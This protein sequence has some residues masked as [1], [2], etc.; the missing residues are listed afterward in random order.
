MDHVRE[1]CA[2][3]LQNRHFQVGP[4]ALQVLDDEGMMAHA[5]QQAALSV[6]F[7]GGANHSALRA[8]E[9]AAEVCPGA[10]ILYCPFGAVRTADEELWLNEFERSLQATR[11][12]RYQRLEGKNYQELLAVLEQEITRL[13]APAPAAAR[14]AALGLIC[15]ESDLAL[16]RSLRTEIQRRDLLTVAYPDFLESRS[17]AMERTR[18]WTELVNT[19]QALLFCW[20]QAKETTVLDIL[21]GL[22]T[23]AKTQSQLAWYLS[24]PDVNQ[25]Q[26]KYP[27][28]ICQT[29]EFSYEALTPFLDPLLKQRS[30]AQ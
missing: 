18:K 6:H 5:L 27:R 23:A 30:A 3:E 8:I 2:T 16:A 7:I 29:G 1:M 21:F 10:T 25:K 22:A 26:Q 4:E 24:Q 19:S 9:I 11:A 17:T 15:D 12:G 14:E 13:R 28:G 20:G